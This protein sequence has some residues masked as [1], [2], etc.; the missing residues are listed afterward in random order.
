MMFRSV[1][2]TKSEGFTLVELVIV[3]AILGILAAISIP[4]FKSSTEKAELASML[5]TLKYLMDG[6]DFYFLKNDTFF[7]V[8]IPSG[9]GK[10]GAGTGLLIF[11]GPQEPLPNTGHQ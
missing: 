11:R 6:E 4:N 1:G 7:K 5:T 2:K 8:N 3:I 10:G 9:D